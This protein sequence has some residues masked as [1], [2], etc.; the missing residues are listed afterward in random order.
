MLGEC[1]FVNEPTATN[2]A[3]SEFG[4]ESA[5]LSFTN[6]EL[7]GCLT[8]RHLW[9]FTWIVLLDNDFPDVRMSVNGLR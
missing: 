5:H 7:F 2:L 8:D 4:G 3:A 9:L 6:T 1:V